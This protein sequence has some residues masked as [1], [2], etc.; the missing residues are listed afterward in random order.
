MEV[1]VKL[2]HPNAKVPAYANTH[3]GALDLTAVSCTYDCEKGYY[4]YDTGVAVEIPRNYVGL[5]FPRSSVSKT[6]LSL[7]NSVGVI[8]FAFCDTIKLRFYWKTNAK[9]YSVGD[10]VGQLMIVPRP[11]I[12]LKV[13]DEFEER[14]DRGGG[15]GSTGN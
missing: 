11:Y 10:R 7:C 3:D 8:D 15:F 4:E 14:V 9:E 1:N 5:L 12:T 2:V 13:V 6:G